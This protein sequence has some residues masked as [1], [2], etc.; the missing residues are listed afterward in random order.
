MT[1][2]SENRL[3]A[4]AADAKRGT[5]LEVQA[6][7]TLAVLS[8][9]VYHF[10]P[11]ALPGG[12]V[13]VDVFFVISG[14]LIIGHLVR[15]MRHDASPRMLLR[16]WARRIRRLLPASIFVLL[17]SLAAALIWLPRTVV[18]TWY[19]QI[20][21]SMLHVQNWLLA[22]NQVDYLKS[23]A[24]ASMV[25]HYWSLSVEEQ[26]YV[27]FP[28]IM[29]LA[30]VFARGRGVA[31]RD[32]ALLTLVA[33]VTVTSFIYSQMLVS[34]GI[35][36]AYFDT[37]ARAW[38]FGVGG[39]VVWGVERTRNS[40]RLN[41]TSRTLLSWLGLAAIVTAC[42]LCSK[43][44]PF[45]GVMALVPVLGTA[46]VIWAG[47]TVARWSAAPLLRARPVQWVGDHSYALYLWHVPVHMILPA[48]IA[49]H[50]TNPVLVSLAV[51]ALTVGLSAFSRRCIETTTLK[52]PTFERMR[53]VY[54]L[55]LLPSLLAAC[56]V[57]SLEKNDTARLETAVTQVTEAVKSADPCIGARAMANA[58]ECAEPFAT[59]D[60][61]D[62]QLAIHDIG[63]GVK[64]DDRCKQI[65]SKSEVVTCDFGS[66]AADAPTIALVGDSHAAM[67]LEGLIPYAEKHDLRIRTYFKAFCPGLGADGLA[68]TFMSRAEAETC[69]AWGKAV[70]K[71]LLAQPSLA[72]VVYSNFTI[73]Y[74]GTNAEQGI[75]PMTTPEASGVLTELK[76]AGLAVAVLRDAPNFTD[77]LPECVEKSG[78][79]YDPCWAPRDKTLLVDYFDP[80]VLAARETGAPVIDMTDMLCTDDGRCHAVIGGL[81]TRFDSHHF[82]SAFSLTLGE[83]LGDRIRETFGIA[84]RGN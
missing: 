25:Q 51:I 60:Q 59:T 61:T 32:A 67:W 7:R 30:L 44:T 84:A 31:G 48:A 78:G 56:G 15:E 6:L 49:P 36:R 12:F 34:Q 50:V 83:S 82:T 14:Y 77:S 26:L 24:E 66:T 53:M 19:E 57:M 62:P 37:F 40:P 1:T 41:D 4:P 42:V 80:M 54:A 64:E 81:I 21:A 63:T 29:V 68:P 58:S 3:R 75:K 72:G 39:L 35:A 27:V 9:I 23:Q 10:W 43:A 52:L 45:P 18:T 73:A 33:L 5:L 22:A 38:E 46:S 11:A 71:D 28:L 16:F 74:G 55:L 65:S 2:T 20:A 76:A 13:G 70:T 47:M 69:A 17:T 8:V 79:A